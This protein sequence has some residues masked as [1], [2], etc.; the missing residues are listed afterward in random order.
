MRG[1]WCYDLYLSRCICTHT[2]TNRNTGPL[3]QEL[4]FFIYSQSS[5]HQFFMPKYCS[6]SQVCP[7]HML[8]FVT[9]KRKPKIMNLELIEGGFLICPS[10]L[11]W[12]K[13]QLLLCKVILIF[14]EGKGK[15]STSAS[16]DVIKCL[17]GES[18]F[19][20][21]WSTLPWGL[22]VNHPLAMCQGSLFRKP[23]LF[24]NMKIFMES[25]F[26]TRAGIIIILFFWVWFEARMR[27]YRYRDKKQRETRASQERDGDSVCFL[28]CLRGKSHAH[29]G[30][31]TGKFSPVLH[32]IPF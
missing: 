23:Q 22:L 3:D 5:F 29:A 4:G 10:A 19:I 21:L 31:S 15:V 2:H 18:S 6:E 20:S 12:Q 7:V 25:Y 32:I 30:P 16:W 14:V 28:Q 27:L 11:W 9:L 17:Q 24:R 8:G 13:K 26:P 1:L